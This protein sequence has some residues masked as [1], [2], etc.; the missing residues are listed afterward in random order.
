MSRYSAR[1]PSVLDSDKYFDK[2]VAIG[3]DFGT[4]SVTLD[5]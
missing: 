2:F 1:M 3:I 4:T 5:W